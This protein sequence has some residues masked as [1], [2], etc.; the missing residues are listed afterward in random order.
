VLDLVRSLAEGGATILMATHEMAFAQGVADRVAFLDEGTIVEE[1]PRAAL[2][3]AGA[4]PHARVP[5]ALH[6]LKPRG[7][8][9]WLVSRARAPQNV[10]DSA[11]IAASWCGVR[12]DLR[13]WCSAE[14]AGSDAAR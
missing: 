14:R 7:L 2:R 4:C 1:G 3:R 11:G 10:T 13:S 5:R 9:A 8:R 6:R 12:R